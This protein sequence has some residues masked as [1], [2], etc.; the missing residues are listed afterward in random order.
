MWAV[1]AGSAE[2]AFVRVLDGATLGSALSNG[3]VIPSKA[4]R[5]LEG[6]LKTTP[7]GW[8]YRNLSVNTV[9]EV[10]SGDLLEFGDV[11]IELIDETIHPED[12]LDAVSRAWKNILNAN[13][14]LDWEQAIDRM[15]RGPFQKSQPSDEIIQ[16]LRSQ[17]DEFSLSGPIERLLF[18]EE[19]SDVL[20][21]AHD[22]IWVERLGSL[23]R[24]TYS[25]STENSYRIYIENL[26]ADQGVRWDEAEPYVD[27]KLKSGE[28]VHLI[29]P[30]LAEDFCLSIRKPRQSAF[31]LEDLRARQMFDD[32][33]IEI[34][35]SL[36]AGGKNLLV[37]GSTGS[38]K[39]TLLKALIL[40]IP[41]HIRT[42][43]LED[44]PELDLPNSNLVFL[45]TRI[46]ARCE[47]PPVDLR[48]LVKQSLRM[49][50]DRIVI[51]EVRGGEAMDL[52]HAMNTGHRGSMASLHANSCRDALFRLE[53]LVQMSDS[54]L[55]ETVIRDIIARNV[56]AV[57]FCGKN[58]QGK[59][60]VSEISMIK[61]RDC[62][63]LILEVVYANKD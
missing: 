57:I 23:S 55:S 30:P 61:G 36:I 2:C 49:R 38:G 63:Q 51:G 54:R 7:S 45:R 12:Y 62:E 1:I 42:L 13:P 8:V 24:T 59:R 32:K 29:G 46:Q 9:R 4:A 37:A 25:F 19:V 58:S 52:L 16:F 43:I 47:M 39:T 33:G 31:S 53:G 34:L 10:R 26:L 50:P 40:E 6:Q 28:R 5:P 18:D 20:I 44:T 14:Q 11:Q 27:F 22:R 35:R 21:Q 3:I 56:D 60:R 15:R 48:Q 41:S 17:F